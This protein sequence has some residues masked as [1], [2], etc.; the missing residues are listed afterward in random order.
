MQPAPVGC[1][2]L[3]THASRGIASDAHGDP[4]EQARLGKLERATSDETI[5]SLHRLGVRYLEDLRHLAWSRAAPWR[6]RYATQLAT[7]CRLAEESASKRNRAPEGAP[8]SF[9]WSG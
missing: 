2:G 1:R 3:L 9:E 7:K 6:A 8:R 5:Q 4:I